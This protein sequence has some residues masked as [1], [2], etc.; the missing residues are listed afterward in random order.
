MKLECK[1]YD[2]FKKKNENIKNKIIKKTYRKFFFVKLLI[3]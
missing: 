1:L 3:F 2:F